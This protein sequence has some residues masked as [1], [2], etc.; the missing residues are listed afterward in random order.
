MTFRGSF[1][2]AVLSLGAVAVAIVIQVGNP[3]LIGHSEKLRQAGTLNMTFT[4]NRIGS[5]LED[6]KLTLSKPG[7]MRYETP[8]TLII[9]NGVHIMTL[10][11]K[12][13]QYFE[14][15]QTPDALKKAMGSDVLWTWSAFADEGF[16]KSITDA[17]TMASRRV[18]GIAVKEVTVSRGTKLA[19]LFI[20]D[21]LGFARGL[22]FQEDR[23]GQKGTV[24]VL[25]NEIA[26]S[27]DP[28]PATDKLF[29]VPTGA[30][31]VEKSALALG[32]K[33]VGP[34][35]SAR[36]GCHVNQPTAGLSLKNHQ[37]VMTGS[38]SGAV[39]V[40]GD[41]DTSIL[42]QVIKGTRAPK[43]PPQG[44]LSPEQMDTLMKWIKDGAKQ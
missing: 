28:M 15:P 27:K 20:D 14:E 6:Q 26:I 9:A 40:P 34:I 22:S 38:R 16:L 3:L 18:K 29:L 1:G 10:E 44:S 41:P 2:M 31:K 33:D 25:A 30:T 23:G 8:A 13:N 12:S 7:L 37:G 5:E 24:L 4:V 35:F 43:M 42:I 19:T 11:K 36:C 32:W 17:R 39:V 21:Q